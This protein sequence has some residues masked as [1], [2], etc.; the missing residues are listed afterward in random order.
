MYILLFVVVGSH[1]V[2]TAVEESQTHLQADE[3]E[4]KMMR[5]M[6]GMMMVLCG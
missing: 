2:Q 4:R 3:V 1:E 6:M 5:M